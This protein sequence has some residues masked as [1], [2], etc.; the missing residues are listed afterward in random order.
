MEPKDKFGNEIYPKTYNKMLG[1]ARILERH[2]YRE[3]KKKPNLF[4][5]KDG[6]VIFF[7]DMR[8]TDM[9]PI[10]E[11]PSPLLYAQFPDNKPMWNQRRLMKKEIETLKIC[12]LSFYD[13][14]EPNGLMFDEYG[15]GYC[16]VCGKDFQDDGL[17]CSLQCARADEYLYQLRCRVC[18]KELNWGKGIEHHLGYKENKTIFVCRS[19]HMKIHRGSKLPWLKPSDTRIK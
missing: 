5:R 17:Y 19:C 13:E 16:K 11:D 15:D 2:N 9:V 3:S 18:G 6:N 1:Y 10:W 14:Y 8:G 12:R 7:A 4:Y